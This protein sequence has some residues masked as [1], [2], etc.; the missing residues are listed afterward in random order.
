[1]GSQRQALNRS[2]ALTLVEVLIASA[3]LLTL[4]GIFSQ[5]LWT[6]LRASGKA[7]NRVDLLTQANFCLGTMAEDME[8]SQPAGIV[9]SS[10]PD[11]LALSVH[12]IASL[13]PYGTHIWEKELVLYLWEGNTVVRSLQTEVKPSSPLRLTSEELQNLVPGNTPRTLASG[14][15]LLRLEDQD[16]ST[17]TR[18]LPFELSLVIEKQRQTNTVGKVELKRTVHIKNL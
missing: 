12:R 1:M 5:V 10:T 18:E 17:P 9:F 13:S 3:L 14:V 16:E 7:M 4:L 11:R 8:R 15:S 2:R 6:G